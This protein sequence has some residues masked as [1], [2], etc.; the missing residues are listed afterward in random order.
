MTTQPDHTI[1]LT[2]LLA[3]SEDARLGRI[4]AAAERIAESTETLMALFASLIG[5]G[6]ATCL[7]FDGT[8]PTT[9]PAVNFLRTGDGTKA[10]A[11]D[12]INAENVDD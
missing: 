12:A 1:G 2:E 5:Q 11:C 6:K 9:Q 3:L 10:F 8:G 4:A 7:S